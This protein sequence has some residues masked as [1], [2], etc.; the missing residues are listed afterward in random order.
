MSEERDP[1]QT[2]PPPSGTKITSETPR[3]V[4]NATGTGA[5]QARERVAIE[6][7]EEAVVSPV[8]SWCSA[9]LPFE[10]NAKEI[11]ACVKA[12]KKNRT[13]VLSDGNTEPDPPLFENG[14]LCSVNLDKANAPD[15]P[16]R[17]DGTSSS[18]SSDTSDDSSSELSSLSED[19][20]DSDQDESDSDRDQDSEQSLDSE[21]SQD[22]QHV[23][24]SPTDV[25]RRHGKAQCAY[26]S[27]PNRSLPG[28]QLGSTNQADGFL[29]FAS[30][31]SEVT[32]GDV[33]VLCEYKK[34]K[35]DALK[36][37]QQVVAGA[38]HLFNQDPVRCGV[39]GITI[40]DDEVS[41]W[42]FSRSHTCKSESFSLLHDPLTL[43]RVL[44]SFIFARSESLGFDSNVRRV[45]AG[46]GRTSRS[47][48]Y[49]LSGET[50][51][52]KWESYYRTRKAICDSHRLCIT[53]RATRV[54]EVERVKSFT[55]M[56]RMDN[57]V[58]VLREV[59]L[60]V[61]APTEREIQQSI[62]ADLDAFGR[63]LQEDPSWNPPH[64]SDFEEDMKAE[65]KSLFEEDDSSPRSDASDKR[66]RKAYE[67]YF[68]TIREDF[69]GSPSR[70]IAEG[71]RADPGLLRETRPLPL[72]NNSATVSD[73]DTSRDNRNSATIFFDKEGN[74]PPEV[75]R[76]PRQYAAKQPYRLI[77]EE[78]CRDLDHKDL[79]S[80]KD[81]FVGLRGCLTALMLLFCAGW[82]HR[83]IS[84]G[85]VLVWK[86]GTGDLQGKLG[87]LEYAKRFP[88]D[89][90]SPDPKTGTAFFMPVEIAQGRRL[91]LA[92]HDRIKRKIARIEGLNAVERSKL[93]KIE[94][95]AS[96]NAGP[97]GDT[98]DEKLDPLQHHF[99]HE[100][101]CI[102]WLSLWAITCRLGSWLRVSTFFVPHN[103]LSALGNREGLLRSGPHGIFNL[104]GRELHPSLELVYDQ[105]RQI[106]EFLADNYLELSELDAVSRASPAVHS[107]AYTMLRGLVNVDIPSDAP[108]LVNSSNPDWKVLT[109][110]EGKA[111]ERKAPAK[112]SRQDES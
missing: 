103:P 73:R 48:V 10:P 16:P 82:V 26:G 86:D 57:R 81:L 27:Q 105:L 42:H 35:S 75:T 56:T 15:R 21:Q 102:W 54:W 29:H 3:S 100:L 20:Q 111:T 50:D 31:R 52:K 93:L 79:T 37:R 89:T 23:T 19:E 108:P 110:G 101:E 95:A 8:D 67:K 18:A 17:S 9:Y 14:Q 30:S 104:L 90:G 80:L 91:A 62:F 28:E 87:D 55:D 59:W 43:I 88:S 94:L 69:I 2:P 39:Y 71:Y 25:L 99:T 5:A 33:T 1:R 36:N 44:V 107:H 45:P 68:L 13:K 41:L 109:Y 74:P 58:V 22:D 98:Q 63:R 60:D 70:D 32:L 65:L 77:Y 47:Y 85:N 66:T 76:P 38:G 83:D 96:R 64:F 106:R 97:S 53:G 6:M 84:C 112:R 7:Q 46:Q 12:L 72:R 40:E 92:E 49:R 51:G 11:A 78:C 34:R 4:R 24:P 61:G